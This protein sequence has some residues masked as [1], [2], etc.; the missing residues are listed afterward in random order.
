MTP[1]PFVQA[2]ARIR[3]EWGLGGLS[4]LLDDLDAPAVVVVVVDVLSFST[5]VVVACEAGVLVRPT[6]LD[7]SP[8]VPPGALLAGVRGDGR[9]SLSPGSLGSL[10]RGTRVVLP[11][12]NGGA[13]AAAAAARGARVLVGSIRN[14]SA[15]RARLRRLLTTDGDSTAIVIA[16]GERWPDGSLRPALEDASGA[17]AVIEGLPV[18]WLSPE[19]A[20]MATGRIDLAAVAD[21]GSARE[22]RDRGFS[23]D[24]AVA[25]KRDA[26]TIVPELVDGWFRPAG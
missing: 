5:A 20:A 10:D 14:G 8:D 16:A 2:G 4:A 1:S 12:P 19:A 24:V 26:S 7:P 9:V 15:T 17:A 3:F 11:S 18:G 13:I 25:L 21:C 23:A 22:L 6:A